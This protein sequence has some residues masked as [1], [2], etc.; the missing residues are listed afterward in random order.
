MNQFPRGLSI[1]G[2]LLI[3]RGSKIEGVVLQTVFDGRRLWIQIKCGA[4]AVDH[5]A[6]IRTKAG[7]ADHQDNRYE[8][9][10]PRQSSQLF[11]DF[12]LQQSRF[13]RPTSHMADCDT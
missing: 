11:H 3:Y 2:G 7:A 9:D 10:V 6:H 13:V 4:H 5:R 12:V 1:R 8:A